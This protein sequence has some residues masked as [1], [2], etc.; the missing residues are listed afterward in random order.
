MRELRKKLWMGL[1]QAIL[2]LFLLINI[3]MLYL[4]Y[5][6]GADALE[7]MPY[8]ILEVTGGSME[9][10]LSPG[11]GVFVWQSP[12]ES[13]KKGDLIV[14]VQYGE[15]ITHQVIELGDGY[16]VAKGTANEA[17]D[18]PVT[19]ENYRARVLFAIPNLWLI[20]T[21]YD[22]AAGFIL[23]SILLFLIIFGKDIFSAIYEAN[24]ARNVGNDGKNKKRG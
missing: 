17:E 7:D 22:S 5:A 19:R 23:F 10:M 11:D 12:F 4:Q 14:F 6:K 24:E 15:L 21:F 13:I 18:E 20:L 8:A 1:I 16:A 3:G 9:P 2:S